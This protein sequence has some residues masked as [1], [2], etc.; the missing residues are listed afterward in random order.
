MLLAISVAVD[1]DG[2][3]KMLT[4]TPQPSEA[5]KKAQYVYIFA[6]LAR[7]R[8]KEAGWRQGWRRQLQ[9]CD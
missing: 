5:S 6:I 7:N 8:I 4:H 9:H 1:G 3:C 2:D